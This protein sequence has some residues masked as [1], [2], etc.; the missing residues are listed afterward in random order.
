[1]IVTIY[2]YGRVQIQY[3]QYGKTVRIVITILLMKRNN[4]VE[5]ATPLRN[6]HVCA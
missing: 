4:L 5:V 1:M 6:R 2:M 3:G